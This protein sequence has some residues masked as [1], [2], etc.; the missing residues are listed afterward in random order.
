MLDVLDVVVVGFLSPLVLVFLVVVFSF[1][2]PLVSEVC[3]AVVVFPVV[4]PVS[5]PVVVSFVV[6][7]PVSLPVVVPFPVVFNVVLVFE[8]AP[9]VAYKQAGSCVSAC[10]DS[11]LELGALDV[12][13]DMAFQRL[14]LHGV[15]TWRFWLPPLVALLLALLSP[16]FEQSVFPFHRSCIP[17]AYSAQTWYPWSP[18]L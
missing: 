16:S 15:H 14:R 9:P 10:L 4:F 6:V 8:Q 17:T 3:F 13:W 12:K 1:V 18:L 5:F 11:D 7:F 2:F